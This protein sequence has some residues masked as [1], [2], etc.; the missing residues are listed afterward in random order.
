MSGAVEIVNGKFAGHSE[1][2]ICIACQKPSRI[3]SLRTEKKERLVCAHLIES[4][5]LSIQS[6]QLIF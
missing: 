3:A 2:E 6:Y 1:R 5:G 4:V